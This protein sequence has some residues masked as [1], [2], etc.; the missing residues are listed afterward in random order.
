MDFKR[1]TGLFFIFVFIA[2]IMAPMA[3]ALPASASGTAG[4][5]AA[6]NGNAGS[7]VVGGTT[8]QQSA[9]L[10]LGIPG[11][12]EINEM[13]PDQVRMFWDQTQGF[14]AQEI[15]SK[16]GQAVIDSRPSAPPL[17]Q[18]FYI[19][20]EEKVYPLSMVLRKLFGDDEEK[21]KDTAHSIGKELTDRVTEE[22][23]KIIVNKYAPG[24][25]G[26]FA[27]LF[28]QLRG[29]PSEQN[30]A[31]LSYKLKLING[32]E[33]PVK[34]LQNV[35]E[36]TQSCMINNAHIQ[37]RVSY[38]SS[39]SNDVALSFDG[40]PSKK[41]TPNRLW[42]TDTIS[43]LDLQGAS[44]LVIP[45]HYEEMVKKLKTW[46]VA[47]TLAT[48]LQMAVFLGGAGYAKTRIDKLKEI[49][50][51]IGQFTET[52]YNLVNIN[53]DALK[54]NTYNLGSRL[55]VTR[56]ELE[57]TMETLDRTIVA[58]ATDPRN[59]IGPEELA[60]KRAVLENV[61][62]ELTA[63]R[64]APE[65]DVTSIYQKYESQL[66]TGV[67]GMS[68]EEIREMRT[69]RE[70]V[71]REA[72]RL[73]VYDELGS[74]RYE[75][76]LDKVKKRLQARSGEFWYR[77]YLGMAWL[78]PG[79]FMFELMDG[80]NLRQLNGKQF[81]DN[82]I[83]VMANNNDVAGEF[84]RTT[85]WMLSGTVTD[86]ISDLTE[87]GIPSAAY[88]VGNLLLVNQ[89]VEE[90]TATVGG[91][92]TPT[93][94]VTS[95]VTTGGKWGVTT[96]WEGRSDAIIAEEL[97]AKSEYARLPMEVKGK[98]WNLKIR[99]RPEFESLYTTMKIIV[100]L[101][102]WGLLGG[103]DGAAI[104]GVRLLTYDWYVT[105]VV[106]PSK[107][108]KDEECS[109][110]KIDEFVSTY[111][112]LTIANQV[113][114]FA[115][116]YG[117]WLKV[118]KESNNRAIKFIGKA[119][120]PGVK[121]FEK[122]GQGLVQLLD[123]VTLAQGYFASHALEYASHCKDDTY[124]I[125]A[126]Q[127]LKKKTGTS[128]SEKL[129][130]VGTNDILS[131]LNVG[132]AVLGIGQEIDTASLNEYVN[133]RSELNNQASSVK[134]D[135]LYYL[136]FKD[137][138]IQWISSTD[139]PNQPAT[140]QRKCL[141]SNDKAGCISK[142]GVELIDK[143]TGIATKIANGDRA[144]NHFESDAFAATIIPN[145]YLTTTLAGC[146]GGVFRVDNANK[147]SLIAN[148]GCV[149][150]AC[151]LGQLQAITGRA[152]VGDL[153]P[154]LGRV[155]RVYTTSGV[156]DISGGIIRFT[157][158]VPINGQAEIRS[159]GID[160]LQA[161]TS[162]QE[163]TYKQ[164]A[165]IVINGDGKVYLHGYIN[166]AN[167]EE[168]VEIGELRTIMTERGRVNYLGAGQVQIFLHI[169]TQ[170]DA[171][172]IKSVATAP[173]QQN[174]CPGDGLPGLKIT[175]VEGQ[176]GIGDAA[177]QELNAA[178]DKIQGC[179][180]MKKL[181]TKDHIYEITKDAD[182]NLVMRV[183]DKNT[184]QV[185]D[186]KINGPIRKE[187]NDLI[188][189]T[190]KGDFK[191]NIGMGENGQPQLSVQGPNGLSELLPLLKANGYGGVL[192]YDPHTGQWGAF[193]GQ[194]L[195]MNP[196]FAKNGQTI[197]GRPDGSVVGQPTTNLLYPSPRTK[198]NSGNSLA[199]LPSWPTET[200]AIA[201]LIIIT[202]LGV[203][204]V[205]FNSNKRLK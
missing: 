57:T 150:A 34:A 21:S 78:G 7:A 16:Q 71:R 19:N 151:I 91:P 175:H 118:F 179:G 51:R 67:G 31:Y 185:T 186:Y 73:E 107:V 139:L 127:S 152:V 201:L 9:S 134:A 93:T 141:D 75:A 72:D 155:T 101:L 182:G 193:N 184:G 83:L 26:E 142:D 79:R 122:Y 168:E 3:Y 66:T 58:L 77:V 166:S 176:T 11:M 28:S 171:S 113:I 61:R 30:P 86:A 88:W 56:A 37:G 148:T 10:P 50:T 111:R 97:G 124:T 65:K 195:A 12:C 153:T 106:N 36:Q 190:D 62:R 48:A 14:Q 162:G 146:P 108:S 43:D 64:L 194:D 191:I 5:G 63:S 178:L 94:S 123:P 204:V 29:S 59:G 130:A 174:Q 45:K 87:E 112:A 145:K 144:F 35:I 192:I 132:K 126:F 156:V 74:V 136:G 38:V 120:L 133:L 183:T 1:F 76:D 189:P 92:V 68:K 115:P 33:L 54:R 84:R 157:G 135:K 140:C 13:T 17:V 198:A 81:A 169:L 177:A 110:A 116:I 180:G 15:N 32:A 114:G 199:S 117:S 2:E 187:G 147:L 158:S 95:F 52:P 70:R 165:S 69:A 49:D 125:V 143:K 53:N 47:D 159:P 103:K 121:I 129:K 60:A 22:E 119:G 27:D 188:V 46:L 172:L 161:A 4:N 8:Q 205:R 149:G 104:A 200:P 39:L 96:K 196:N 163:V 137:A 25:G 128:I 18:N 41:N 203:A 44:T 181:E 109:S 90:T 138:S 85:N 89:A 98:T 82:Y 40:A 55:S 202:L 24:R 42:S 80:L 23:A 170:V 6:I 154:V 197:S 164:A 160:V 105:D 100:P 99:N 131:K 102:S 167:G 20:A 173:V